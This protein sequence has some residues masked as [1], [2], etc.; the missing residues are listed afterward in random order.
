MGRRVEVPAKP[1]RVISLVPSQSELLHDLGL[2]DRLVGVTKFCIHPQD[3]RKAKT[4]VGGTKQFR[5]EAI[6][7]L[8]PDLIIG[9]KEENYQEGIHQLA[10]KYPVWM[11]DIFTLEDALD[12]IRKV[13]DLC[14]VPEK[15]AS[16]ATGIRQ[17]FDTL[18]LQKKGTALYLIW[19]GPYMAAGRNTFINEML[20]KAGYQNVVGEERYPEVSLESVKDLS[21]DVIMLSSEP[22]PFAEKHKKVLLLAVPEARIELVDGE[23]MSWYGS[24][25]LKT[26]EYLKGL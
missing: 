26:A 18:T 8:Q 5:F 4:I 22:F 17:T 21:P 2:G 14:D 13:S 15:G 20:N 10:E 12:M 19:K 23:L 9:N 3:L 11:S 6:D 24:R 1:K 25:L 16:M 7:A